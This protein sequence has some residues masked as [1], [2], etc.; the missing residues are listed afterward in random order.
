MAVLGVLKF[1]VCLKKV[2]ISLETPVSFETPE[3]LNA[4]FF[5]LTQ[6]LRILF[7]GFEQ[8][9]AEEPGVLNLFLSSRLQVF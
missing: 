5:Q 6:H 3:K 8:A 7:F 2:N 4:F 9:K 1:Q